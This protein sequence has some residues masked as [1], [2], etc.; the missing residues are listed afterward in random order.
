MLVVDAH[1]HVFAPEICRDRAA[2]V[3][4]DPWFEHLYT[5]PRAALVTAEDLIASMD[6]AGIDRSIIAGFPW[7]DPALCRMHNDYM[8]EAATTYPDR[9]SWLA[10]VVPSAPDAA[11]EAARC[12]ALGAVGIGELNAD[13]QGFDF[14]EPEPLA[15]LVDACLQHDRPVM[16]HVSEPVGHVYPGKGTATPEKFVHFLAAYPDLRVVAAHW[17]GGLPFYELMPEVASIARNVAYDSAAST[18]LYRFEVFRAVLDIVGPERVLMASDYP[19]LRQDRFLRRVRD[20]NLREE[21][22]GPVLG[23]NA[24][25]VYNLPGGDAR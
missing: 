5:N 21:E 9:L 19:V 13:A 12:F 24:I 4:R 1:T 10:T 25:R 2:Y 16:F 6:A 3:A 23:G 22:V 8:A 17:G 14:R 11:D 18:Y 20:A 7:R 15:A